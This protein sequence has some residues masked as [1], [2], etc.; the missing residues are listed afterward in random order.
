MTILVAGA[1]ISGLT[2]ALTCHELGL[3]VKV[4]EA[5]RETQPLDVGINLQS[6]AVRELF[7]LGLEPDLR[8]IGIEAEEWALFF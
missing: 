6:N 7:Q 2:F 8:A 4:F 1:G 5:V 3:D